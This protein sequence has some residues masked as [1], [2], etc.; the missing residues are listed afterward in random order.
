MESEKNNFLCGNLNQIPER[1]IYC[2]A[3]TFFF[4]LHCIFLLNK[5]F[6]LTTNMLYYLVSML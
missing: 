4:G 2:G 1:I 3:S 6:Y 5:K